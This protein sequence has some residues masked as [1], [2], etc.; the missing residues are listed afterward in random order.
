MNKAA[1]DKIING[2][3][4]ATELSKEIADQIEFLKHKNIIPG[5]A[6]ILVGNNPASKIYVK[7]KQEMAKAVGIN[8]QVIELEENT[9]GRNL[10]NKINYL[11]NNPKINGILV[12]LPL[13]KH[14]DSNL[15]LNSIHPFKDVDGLTI[16]N[17]GKL[18]TNQKDGLVPCTPQGCLHLIKRIQHNLK[19]KN[20]VVVGRS[21]IVGRPMTNILLNND[22]T[23]TTIHSY[24]QEPEKITSRAD[25]L[26]VAVGKRKLIKNNWVKKDAIVID[27]GINRYRDEAGKIKLDGDVDF[28]NVIEKVKA[29]TPVPGGVGPMT[30]ACL[31][32]NTLKATYMQRNINFVNEI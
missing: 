21:N 5:L 3:K 18:I 19:G 15:V 2:V 30:I 31:L 28:E 6:V 7:R 24:T 27:V 22:C 12:Q 32:N 25:I 11:N 23:V 10:I 9:S 13:P 17:I 29:I 4:I 20:A 14:I 8:S 16:Y 1:T 26:V